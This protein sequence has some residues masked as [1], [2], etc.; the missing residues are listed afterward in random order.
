MKKRLVPFLLFFMLLLC[1][2][3]NDSPEQFEEYVDRLDRVS[4]SDLMTIFSEKREMDQLIVGKSTSIIDNDR[5]EKNPYSDL[6]SAEDFLFDGCNVTVSI[7]Y[8]DNK[9]DNT[10]YAFYSIGPDTAAD[11]IDNCCEHF[12]DPSYIT[13]EDDTICYAWSEE[14]QENLILL[15]SKKYDFLSFS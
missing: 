3:S 11:I 12:G 8:E 15:Y 14:G 9:I 2:C 10:N 1:S 4:S 6:Y 5:F 7:S 13:E